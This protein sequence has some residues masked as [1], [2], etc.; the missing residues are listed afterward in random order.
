MN[1]FDAFQILL[2][3]YILGVLHG[4]HIAYKAYRR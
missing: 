2:M 3:G 1:P 4:A